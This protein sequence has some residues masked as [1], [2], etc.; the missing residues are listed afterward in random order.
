M[1]VFHLANLTI[2][3]LVSV[4]DIILTNTSHGLINQFFIALSNQFSLKVLGS[5]SYFLEVEAIYTM[6][7]L[8][9][10]Q[11]KCIRDLLHK[12]NMD[13]AKEVTT[14]LFFSASLKI[15]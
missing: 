1:F 12:T 13:D 11:H 4:D 8:F 10:S 3:L 15:D 14:P 5:W 6:K 7:D 9:L 2:L